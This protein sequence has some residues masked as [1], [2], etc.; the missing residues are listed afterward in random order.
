MPRSWDPELAASPA[1]PSPIIASL[2]NVSWNPPSAHILP[3]CRQYHSTWR[4]SQLHPPD[5]VINGRQ[6]RQE[7]QLTAPG[8]WL[9]LWGRPQG[10]RKVIGSGGPNVLPS[11]PVGVYGQG[12]ADEAAGV[13][14]A[15]GIGVFAQSINVGVVVEGGG[16]G[17]NAT[18]ATV[19]VNGP[20]QTGVVAASNGQPGSIGRL[21]C[22]LRLRPEAPDQAA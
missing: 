15:G 20:G 6:P 11:N 14:G 7:P 19:G 4:L 9:A 22:R 2:R 18:G 1:K 16:T 8:N 5:G 3:L 17:I 13:W 10:S 12:G 21:S